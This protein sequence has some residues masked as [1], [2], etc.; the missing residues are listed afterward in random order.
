[1]ACVSPE[2]VLDVRGNRMEQVRAACAELAAGFERCPQAAE[3]PVAALP[4]DLVDRAAK[5]PERGKGRAEP[6]LGT[7]FA[8]DSVQA[9]PADRQRR[10]AAIGE[11][12]AFAGQVAQQLCRERLAERGAPAERRRRYQANDVS[13]CF[14][15][16]HALE[17][18]QR[19]ARGAV[20]SRPRQ[21]PEMR[22][23][24]PAEPCYGGPQYLIA[25]TLAGQV[26]LEQFQG[27]QA[28]PAGVNVA[29]HNG[30]LFLV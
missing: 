4:H 8:C 27:A 12:R 21:P 2:G 10:S 30:E 1:M 3:F 11:K 26:A 20:A 24:V 29:E 9:E 17:R 5:L 7:D 16:R 23:V 13:V 14:F 15:E 18:G 25:L 28:Q 6:L 22:Q 19:N